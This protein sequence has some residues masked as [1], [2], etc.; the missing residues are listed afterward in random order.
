MLPGHGCWLNAVKNP[1]DK[2]SGEVLPKLCMIH[3]KLH[4][5]N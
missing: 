4:I 1:I 3:E 2:W 5:Q